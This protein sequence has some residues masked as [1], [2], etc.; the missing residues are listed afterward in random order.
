VVK[1]A[2][3]AELRVVVDAVIAVAAGAV[4]VAHHLL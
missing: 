3:A 4:L 2:D 1:L